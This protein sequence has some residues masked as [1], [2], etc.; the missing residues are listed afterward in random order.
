[1]DPMAFMRAARPNMDPESMRSAQ[2]SISMADGSTRSVD[3][4][5][6][7]P[8]SPSYRSKMPPPP[9]F[10]CGEDHQPGR[11][12]DHPWMQEPHVIS[13]D[14]EVHQT[15]DRIR[16]EGALE[17]GNQPYVNGEFTETDAKVREA[18]R[19]MTK[20]V[21]L[22]VG[23]SD[24]YVVAVEEAPDWDTVKSFKVSDSVVV[25]LIDLARALGVKVTDKTGGDLVMLEEKR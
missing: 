11:R 18:P 1:M 7:N 3:E 5:A 12:Y 6:T 22:Y 4:L 25:D 20:R 8:A 10:K 17:H 23:K 19:V 13:A 9:C 15:I 14:P 21:A 2:Q 24:T 16:Q